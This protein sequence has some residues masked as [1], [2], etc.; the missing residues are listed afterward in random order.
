MANDV[1]SQT[2]TA[3]GVRIIDISGTTVCGGKKMN[4][5]KKDKAMTSISDRCNVPTN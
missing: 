1:L 5:K 2:L 4:N 3:N